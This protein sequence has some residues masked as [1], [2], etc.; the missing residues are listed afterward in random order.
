MR[1]SDWRFEKIKMV[2]YYGTY[3]PTNY[4]AHHGILG[5][6]WGKHNGPPYPIDAPD[7]SKSE[8]KAGWRKSLDGSHKRSDNVKVKRTS[9]KTAD[10]N[11]EKDSKSS[12]SHKA[13]NVAL[14]VAALAAI[15]GT[16]YYLYKTGKLS[17]ITKLGQS[18]LE[19]TEILGNVNGPK[20][21][22]KKESIDDTIRFANPTRSNTNCVASSFAGFLRQQGLGVTAK[23]VKV[24]PEEL[25]R[26]CFKNANSDSVKHVR[27]ERLAKSPTETAKF[28]LKKFGNDGYGMISVPWLQGKGHEFNFR[29]REGRVL[30]FDSQQGI[31]G[32]DLFKFWRNIDPNKEISFV[33]LDD[34]FTGEDS[35]DWD[36][37]RQ[38]LNF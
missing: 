2:Y 5:M 31:K 11:K 14:T 20:R 27:A 22:L 26:A 38:F 3:R 23:D 32:K 28:L 9:S 17:S 24:T 18:A 10:K 6:K 30:Y 34:L 35:I 21:L 19:N 4:L 1:L 16:S 15:G 8:K 33:R 7:H 25:V 29:I 36:A 13:R 37:A 12:T